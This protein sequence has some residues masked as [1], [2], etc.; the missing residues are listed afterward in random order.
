VS[1]LPHMPRR[2]FVTNLEEWS[3][4]NRDDRSR[5]RLPARVDFPAAGTHRD[6][7]TAASASRCGFAMFFVTS[8]TCVAGRPLRLAGRP[9]RREGATCAA[10]LIQGR[11]AR[12]ARYAYYP[13]GLWS[14][15]PVAPT[16]AQAA[17]TAAR[18]RREA[19]VAADRVCRRKCVAS[20][21]REKARSS[22]NTPWKGQALP[23]GRP[24]TP[25]L[26]R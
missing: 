15:S 1:L 17:A 23:C 19:G 9:P 11:C 21:A 20:P 4:P 10:C 14:A 16:E 2:W 24:G 22:A 13:G 5:S 6:C 7:T 26:H 18:L 25:S 12:C 3:D 8:S